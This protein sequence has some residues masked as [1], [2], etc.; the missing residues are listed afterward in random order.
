MNHPKLINAVFRE[1][2]V[3][4]YLD[5]LGLPKGDFPFTQKDKAAIE[6][7]LMFVAIACSFHNHKEHTPIINEE[8][9]KT[10]WNANYQHNVKIGDYVNAPIELRAISP[11]LGIR[12]FFGSTNNKDLPLRVISAAT[13][14]LKINALLGYFEGMGRENFVNLL[15]DEVTTP[16]LIA[17]FI[18]LSYLGRQPELASDE[19]P[20]DKLTDVVEAQINH[21]KNI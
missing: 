1:K 21:I 18:L 14:N 13:A 19:Q 9:T 10:L 6:W 17:S 7:N 2:Y 4:Y 12:G 20:L 8:L 16:P 11:Y 3:D 5:Q 15:S